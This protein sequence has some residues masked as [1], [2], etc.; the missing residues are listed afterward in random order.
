MP[1]DASCF[2]MK[3]PCT[4]MLSKSKEPIK[5]FPSYFAALSLLNR[6]VRLPNSAWL[7]ARY[8]VGAIRLLAP[9]TA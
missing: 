4:P 1:P 5:M 7:H 3:H 2:I 9:S 6:A 8:G